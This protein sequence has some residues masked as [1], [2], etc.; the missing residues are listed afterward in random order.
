MERQS[1]LLIHANG[2][3][4]IGLGHIMRTLVL[5]DSLKKDIN[6]A[7]I[8]C[9]KYEE[10]IQILRQRGYE[11]FIYKQ[12][13]IIQTILDIEAD[14]IL[15][16]SYDIDQRYIDSIRGKFKIVGYI[17]DNALLP[18]NADFILNQNFG[19]EDILY[20]VN[21]DCRLLLGS[22]YI[23]NR[24]EFRT[25]NKVAIKREVKNIL[26]TVGGSDCSNFTNELVEMVKCMPYNFHVVIGPVFPYKEML[27]NKYYMHK[28]ICFHTEPNM[29]QLMQKADLAISSCGSTLYELGVLG[30]P[31]I[32]VAVAENQIELA[33]RMSIAMMIRYL[34]QIKCLGKNFLEKEIYQL[35]EDKKLREKMQFENKILLNSNGVEE[36]AQVIR[37]LID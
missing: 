14:C 19:A 15:T 27:I 24:E 33:T 8:S 31:T 35:A 16:D 21:K 9:E 28:H 23:L 17:D 6:I 2:G 7:Y 18:Y 30:V 12:D 36:V 20:K 4:D 13:E 32:G 1:T 25:A 37:D 5:A 3:R 26:I 10:G 29:L 11:T 22:Q 34:G